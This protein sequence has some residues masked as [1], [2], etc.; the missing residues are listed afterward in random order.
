MSV[1]KA[2]IDDHHGDDQIWTLDGCRIGRYSI[3]SRKDAFIGD[4]LGKVEV[5]G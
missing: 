1:L 2:S 5:E 4:L 3:S